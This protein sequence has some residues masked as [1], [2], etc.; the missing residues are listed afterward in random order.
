MFV[1]SPSVPSSQPRESR[2]VIGLVSHPSLT[3]Q[4]SEGSDSCRP[5][6]SS[7]ELHSSFHSSQ[8]DS[9][10]PTSPRASDCCST[11]ANFDPISSRGS[12]S[13]RHKSAMSRSFRRATAQQKLRTVGQGRME[14]RWKQTQPEQSPQL[15][16]HRPTGFR[17]RVRVQGSGF[18][19]LGSGLGFRVQG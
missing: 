4:Q 11:S 5:E 10:L 9:L 7:R 15:L 2:Q 13:S 19:V 1:P 6:K 17:A 3:S 14:T 16:L 8:P 12:L 18:R